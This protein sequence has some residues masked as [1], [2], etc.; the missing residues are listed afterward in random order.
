MTFFCHL[1]EAEYTAD[2]LNR[3]FGCNKMYAEAKKKKINSKHS[4]IPLRW[5]LRQQK[6]DDKVN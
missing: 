2:D 4:V 5:G 1:N 3:G 6:L